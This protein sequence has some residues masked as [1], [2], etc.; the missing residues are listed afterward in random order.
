MAEED[1]NNKL[2]Q[3]DQQ[4]LKLMDTITIMTAHVIN[5][6][7]MLVEMKQTETDLMADIKDAFNTDDRKS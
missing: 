7:E 1:L 3:L 5:L 4:I 2:E 6:E